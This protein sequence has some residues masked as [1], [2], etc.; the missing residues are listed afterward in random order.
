MPGAV[1]LVTQGFELVETDA[2]IESFARQ[3]MAGFDRWNELGFDQIAAD[4][5]ARIP[6]RKAGERR[7]LDGNGDLLRSAPL[8]RGA[9]DRASLAEAL[10]PS[11]WY[12]PS[13]RGPKLG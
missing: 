2:I 7:Q 5:F 12:D 1:S 10:A 4:Y 8:E 13:L 9:P 3:L 6:P 11:A